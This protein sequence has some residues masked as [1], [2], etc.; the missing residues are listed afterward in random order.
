[1]SV[2]TSVGSDYTGYETDDSLKVMDHSPRS[3]DMEVVIFN[4]DAN[5][6]GEDNYIERLEIEDIA[7]VGDD[8]KSEKKLE[9]EVCCH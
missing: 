4:N 2:A 8:K 6:K 5:D 1:M 3:Q 7:P 9:I